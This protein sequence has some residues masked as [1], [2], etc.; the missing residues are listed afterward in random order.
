M[1]PIGIIQVRSLK[2]SLATFLPK[3]CTGCPK[4]GTHLPNYQPNSQCF[5]DFNQHLHKMKP[6][7]IVQARPLQYSLVIFVLTGCPK[8]GTKSC[9]F[10]KNIKIQLFTANFFR[11]PNL[12]EQFRRSHCSIFTPI[13]PYRV[14]HKKVQLR[15]KECHKIVANQGV[16]LFKNVHKRVNVVEDIFIEDIEIPK[17]SGMDEDKP[18]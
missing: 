11:K 16:L 18:K 13:R 4:N 3:N 8:N 5:C 14:V 15:K 9:F 7:G 10:I 2:C 12:L 17:L 6:I 1:K